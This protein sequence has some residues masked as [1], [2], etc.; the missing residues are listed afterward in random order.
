MYSKSFFK[1]HLFFSNSKNSDLNLLI[2][3]NH[4]LEEL[5]EGIV[6]NWNE[7][8]I[9]KT[10]VLRNTIYYFSQKWVFAVVSI[11]WK[12][13]KFQISMK[14]QSLSSLSFHE[15][16]CSPTVHKNHL[17]PVFQD[18]P[19]YCTK[20]VPKNQNQFCNFCHGDEIHFL[21][22]AQTLIY[23][24]LKD[25]WESLYLSVTYFL[26]VFG[27]DWTEAW[28]HT[29]PQLVCVRTWIMNLASKVL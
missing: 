2:L 21:V 11:P 8:L 25:P 22:L 18:I 3:I 12:G 4:H 1:F 13:N 24:Q 27:V 19:F 20:K 16:H 9:G 5:K 28:L 7:I 6:K 14:F 17:E 10:P 15:L 29:I 26:E 23:S